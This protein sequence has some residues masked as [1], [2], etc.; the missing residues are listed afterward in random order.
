M[1]GALIAAVGNIG[2]HDP[3]CN[4]AHAAPVAIHTGNGD[5]NIGDN[6]GDVGI[7]GVGHH[8]AGIGVGN[9]GRG[10]QVHLA[11]HL[12]ILNGGVAAAGA[13]HIAE[14]SLIRSRG[15]GGTIVDAHVLHGMIIA[16]KAALEG[17]AGGSAAD[18]RP[19]VVGQ[20][21]ISRQRTLDGV[22]AA[23]D[24]VG[25]PSQL[26]S[27]TDLIHAA[28]KGGLRLGG[29][30][31]CAGGR[32][33]QRN[34]LGQHTAGHIGLVCAAQVE[35]AVG[36]IAAGAGHRIGISAIG[37]ILILTAAVGGIDLARGI[38]Q[39]HSGR[40][41]GGI[42]NIQLQLEGIPRN[43]CNIHIGETVQAEVHC[44]RI[45]VGADAGIRHVIQ[46]GERIRRRVHGA[47][48]ITVGELNISGAA[49]AK[50]HIRRDC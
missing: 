41:G 8:A 47:V 33:R 45:E 38:R 19:V 18:G 40:G 1:D 9:A 49:G 6:A 2:I 44:N 29:A 28:G 20:V 7:V 36:I 23:V 32:G 16:V 48:G 5:V 4:T 27:G 10:G 22:A 12:Q 43:N 39:R 24:L 50:V 3:P 17:R 25:K 14:Q 35:A 30:V 37:Q 13:V 34:G 42:G 21:H 15:S 11:G 26:R 31:P 46:S